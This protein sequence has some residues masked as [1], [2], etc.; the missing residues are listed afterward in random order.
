MDRQLGLELSDT[1]FRC[2]E[3]GLLGGRDAWLQAGVDSRLSAPG[4]NR[5][6]ANLELC[7]NLGTLPTSVNQIYDS[8]PELR[9]VAPSCPIAPLRDYGSGVQFSPSVKVGAR[10]SLRQTRGGSIG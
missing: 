8:S 10:Q 3:F 9:R 6:L 7:S 5:L 4:V 2:R 1:P